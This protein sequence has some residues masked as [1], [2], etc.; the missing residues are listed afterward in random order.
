VVK[1][2]EGLITTKGKLGPGQMILVD[3]NRHLFL[4]DAQVKN[5]LAR[6]PQYQAWVAGFK[7]LATETRPARF[8]LQPPPYYQTP[9][10]VNT[11]PLWLTRFQTAFGYTREEIA[12][13]LRPMAE[14][15]KEPTGSM[16]DDA[17]LALLSDQPRPLFH[18]FKQRFAQVTSPPLDPLRETLVMSLT[19]RLGARANLLAESA[20]HAHLIELTSPVLTDL[21][22]ENLKRLDDPRFQTRTIAARYPVEQGREGLQLALARLCTMA[23]RAID[24]GQTILVLSDHG[25]DRRHAPIPALLAVGAVHQ[26]LLRQ[27]RR[28]RVSLVAE[29]GEVREV[30]HLACLLAFGANAVNPYLALATVEGL[31]D[32]AAVRLNLVEARRNTIRAMEAGLLKIM[33]KMGVSTVESYAGA[34]LMEAIGLS[35]TLVDEFFS[36]TVSRLGGIGL[37]EI[38]AAVA[39]W[40]RAAFADPDPPALADPGFYHV[41]PGGEAHAHTP[42]TGQALQRA[43]RMAGALSPAA[44]APASLDGRPRA[45][46]GE[47]FAA[48]YAAYQEFAGLL[49]QHRPISPR[50]LLDFVDSGRAPLALAEVEPLEAILPRFAT[51]AMSH[52]AL[53][54]EA[55]QTLAVAANRL[56]T[57][58]NSGEGGAEPGT[59]GTERNNSTKQVASG[60]FG[61]TPAYVMS[62]G[63]LQIKIAQG[64]KPG[65]G[66]QLPGA[67]VSAEIAAMRHTPVGATLISPPPHHDVYSLEDLAQLIYDLKQVNPQA[68]V[69]VKLVAE[70]GVGAVAA[71]VVK[72]GADAVHLSGHAGGTGAAAWSS[73]KHAGLP[74]ELGLAEIQHTLQ[75]HCLRGR[76][77]LS[78]DG[79]LQ[80]GRDVVI[81]AMLGADEYHFGTAALVAEGCL[82]TRACHTNTCP[83]GIATQDPVLRAN[84]AGKPEHVMAYLHYVAQEVREILARWGYRHLAEI[85]GRTEL[86]A[87]RNTGQPVS[88]ALNL[89]PLL[90]QADGD[91]PRHFQA[92]VEP[93]PQAVNQL[94]ALLLAQAEPA[95]RDG[96][97]VQLDL[98]IATTDRA[99]GATLSGAIARQYGEAGLPEGTIAVTFHGS[100][101]QSF[102][103]FNAS[104]LNLTL[105]G[106][107]N[108]GV[109]KGMNGGQLV[110]RPPLK[111]SRVASDHT[112]IGNAGLY[113]ATGGSL[114]IAGQAGDRFAVRNSG[115]TAVVEGIG[116]HGCEYMTGGV[117]IVLGR[118]GYNFGAGL[119]GGM[120]F[121]LDES[122]SLTQRLNAD[123]VQIVRVTGQ[124][125]IGLL[126]LLITRHARLTGS[127]RAR[128]VLDHW[129]SQLGAF[130]KV[131][132]KGTVGSTGMRPAALPTLELS[133]YVV[134]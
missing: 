3:L 91:G 31:V 11:S 95:L 65:E 119:S 100:A 18:Y 36:G 113:G 124:N 86:L 64:A 73:I 41:N 19:T 17:A 57:A 61:L 90:A 16:G 110:V 75:Q 7:P 102:G 38:A 46:P 93:S 26:H 60:R 47:N 45:F 12:V 81:A 25:V 59:F 128:Y 109:G 22:L 9:P 39:Q 104:G 122:H 77:R 74:F 97:P 51:A 48:G 85:I 29:S 115:A 133:Q 120:A 49:R 76:V 55:H 129:S 103:A 127:E 123:M 107:A 101:G 111:S 20:R 72:S 68:G 83:A 125:D 105:I 54:A 114:F 62:A 108:D 14:S 112:I 106:E 30:H 118:A 42:A 99:V 6:R 117:V 34:Q 63:Q 70:A 1:V 40:H 69:A 43:V 96:L 121:V 67:K 66:G 32:A 94:N 80:T 35:Q 24:H 131:A 79:G 134:G 56:G 44:L 82:M 89:A 88:D 37:D 23:G 130:W 53:S 33:S 116:D 98:P 50:D 58:S 15:G 2:D 78:T 27:G 5:E 84:F 92:K 8:S 10:K 71:G 13:I 4:T 126:R 28:M 132:P 87:Q 21:D 52:G